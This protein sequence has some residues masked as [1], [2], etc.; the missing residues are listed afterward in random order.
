METPAG[1]K[2]GRLGGMAEIASIA[3]RRF[4]TYYVTKL[5]RTLLGKV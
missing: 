1:M 4:V 5:K 2:R 3:A